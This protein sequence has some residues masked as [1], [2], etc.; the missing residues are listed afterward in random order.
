MILII[1]INF[2][3]QKK[4]FCFIFIIRTKGMAAKGPG[5]MVPSLQKW[6]K[7]LKIIEMQKRSKFQKLTPKTLNFQ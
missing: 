2:F 5:P 4:K 3:P 1:K 7:I 6:G